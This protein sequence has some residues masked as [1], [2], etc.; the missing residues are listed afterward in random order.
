[1]QHLINQL[2]V[3][4]YLLMAVMEEQ[5]NIMYYLVCVCFIFIFFVEQTPN[6]SSE[7]TI[8]AVSQKLVRWNV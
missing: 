1:M 7:V 3:T 8:Y 4:K 6:I 5:I 2:I